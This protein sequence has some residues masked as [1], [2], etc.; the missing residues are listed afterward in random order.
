MMHNGR[1]V[2]IGAATVALLQ[3]GCIGCGG[4]GGEGTGE[5][6]ASVPPAATA[7][8]T[9]PE[10]QLTGGSKHPGYPVHETSQAAQP[11]A[12][13][14]DHPPITGAAGQGGAMIPEPGAPA[15][16]KDLTWT[17]PKGWVEEP[18]ANAMRRAQYRV[19]GPAGDGECV[20]FY[21]GAGQ[22]GDPESNAARWADQFTLPGGGPARDALKS[23]R[24]EVGAMKVLM[25][26]VAGTY[27]GGGMMG[28]PQT[29]KPD[30]MLL[31]AVAV[32]ADANWFFKFTGPE[33]TVSSQRA[34]F[35]G[36][37]KSLRKRA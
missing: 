32:G 23:S 5:G 10:E 30:F 9:A 7:E 6:A 24:I 37:V 29:P 17:T 31:G 21:F 22:G 13:P 15:P 36:L 3:L 35:E 2:I 16:G 4:R 20:V 11:G 1:A 18:P 8:Q 26:E 27:E 25:V 14:P 12:L 19:P 34:A 28:Q 33:K